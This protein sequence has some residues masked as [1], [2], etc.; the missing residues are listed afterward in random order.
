V[1]VLGSYYHRQYNEGNRAVIQFLTLEEANLLHARRLARRHG[2]WD[3]VT[4]AMQGLHMLY[5]Y[6][7]RGAEWARLVAAI[8]PDYCTP[9]DEPVPGREEQY[10][11][12]MGY[13]VDLALAQERNL[14]LAAALQAK[15]VAWDR[16]QAAAALAL[17]V[18]AALDNVQRHRIRTLGVSVTI[19][20]QILR[21][22]GS[23]DCVQQYEASIQHYQRIKDTAAEAIAHYNLGHAYKDLPAILDLDAAEAAYQRSLDLHD[24]NDA[25]GRSRCIKQIGMVHYE[26]FKAARQQRAPAATRL[27]H[28]QAAEAHYQQALAL[29]PATAIADLGPIHNQLGILYQEVGQTERAREH[30]EQAAHYFEQSD[31][32]YYAGNVRENMAIMY[33]DAA[34]QA[35]PPAQQRD[36]LQR[37]R[38]YAQAAQRDYQHFQG[39]AAADEANAQGLIDDIGQALAALPQ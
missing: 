17:P 35:E 36:L 30:Y 22:Q 3:P 28:A 27:Q 15:L 39:R 4:A 12:V 34:E 26:R 10:T 31:N 38:A 33:K 13:R 14:A 6:Q 37:A 23:G 18:D 8:A 20:G 24:P 11:L 19:L 29:C 25:L 1:G 21:G 9:A 5:A 7:G 16:Q 2:W 32:R